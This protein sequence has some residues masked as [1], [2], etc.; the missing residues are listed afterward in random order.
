MKPDE[1]RKANMVIFDIEGSGGRVEHDP[2]STGSIVSIGAVDFNTGEEFYQE[3]RVMEGRGYNEGALRVNG[4]TKEGIYDTGKQS[5]LELLVKFEDFCRAHDSTIIGAWGD[6]DR[7]MLLAAYE[8]YGREWR[9]PGTYANLKGLSKQILGSNRSGLS[10][11]A[12]KLNI[13]PET[14]PH[15]GINGARLATENVFMLL[16]GK[17]YYESYQQCEIP[18][19]DRAVPDMHVIRIIERR[20]QRNV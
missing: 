17:H 8:Y 11:T 4:F 14:Y 12:M 16:F 20:K 1:I 18:K 15:I 9:L 7:K 2:Y 3:C 5:V 13:P 6:Y 10:N 19:L